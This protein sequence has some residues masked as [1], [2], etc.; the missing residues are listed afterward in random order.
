MTHDQIVECLVTN[1]PGT[2]WSLSGNTYEGFIWLGN[3]AIKPTANELG[4]E[5]N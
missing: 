3:T 2:Q 4:L 1:Y 5:D